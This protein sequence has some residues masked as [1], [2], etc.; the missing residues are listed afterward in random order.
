MSIGNKKYSQISGL[1]NDRDVPRAAALPNRTSARSW[2]KSESS[3]KEMKKL[4][5]ELPHAKTC[6]LKCQQGNQKQ[7]A[8]ITPSA[9]ISKFSLKSVNEKETKYLNLNRITNIQTDVKPSTTY[10]S[11]ATNNTCRL[12]RSVFRKDEK[13]FLSSFEKKYSIH[14]YNPSKLNN[15]SHM[16]KPD[17]K[18]ALSLTTGKSRLVKKMSVNQSDHSKSS[19]HLLLNG[20]QLSSWSMQCDNASVTLHNKK[21]AIDS[22]PRRYVNSYL[23]SHPFVKQPTDVVHGSAKSIDFN[24]QKSN[25]KAKRVS[26]ELNTNGSE[27]STTKHINRNHKTYNKSTKI[28]AS[29]YYRCSETEPSEQLIN[30]ESD[31]NI[32]S[33]AVKY[34]DIKSTN[35]T[36]WGSVSSSE[37]GDDMCEFDRQQ[38]FRVHEMFEEID[39]ILFDNP[40]LDLQDSILRYTSITTTNVDDEPSRYTNISN[41]INSPSHTDDY[42]S[43]GL[44]NLALLSLHSIENRNPPYQYPDHFNSTVT[45]C[46]NSIPCGIQDHLFYECKDWLSRFPHLRVVGKQIKLADENES[47]FHH[48]DS[49]FISEFSNMINVSS[50]TMNTP[51]NMRKGITT[52]RRLNHTQIEMGKIEEHLLNPPTSANCMEEEIFAIDGEYEEFMG[53]VTVSSKYNPTCNIEQGKQLSSYDHTHFR[54]KLLFNDKEPKISKSHQSNR[55]H[56]HH[57]YHSYHH[58]RHKH[59]EKSNP[60]P[61]HS[62]SEEYNGKLCI[63][64]DAVS[65]SCFPSSP[66][67]EL[68]R[69]KQP[70]SL[71]N[72]YSESDFTDPPSNSV[73]MVLRIISEQLWNDLTQ[74]TEMLL[75]ENMFSNLNKYETNGS[76]HKASPH[77]PLQS[78][79]LRDSTLSRYN[80]SVGDAQNSSTLTS[81]R[82]PKQTKHSNLDTSNCLSSQHTVQTHES[83]V[84]LADLLQISTK[85]LQTRE[86]SLVQENNDPFTKIQYTGSNTILKDSTN[87]H[88]ISSVGGSQLTSVTMTTITTALSRISPQSIGTIS[89]NRP[90]SSL[91]NKSATNVPR[92]VL[93]TCNSSVPEIPR[94]SRTS[95]VA[96][97]GVAANLYHNEKL[98]PLDR[99]RTPVPLQYSFISEEQSFNTVSSTTAIIHFTNTEN[100]LNSICSTSLAKCRDLNVSQLLSSAT[101]SNALTSLPLVITTTILHTIPNSMNNSSQISSVNTTNMM[102][103]TISSSDFTLPPLSNPINILST[104]NTTICF[105]PS[106]SSNT[107][108]SLPN[109]KNNLSTTNKTGFGIYQVSEQ[110]NQRT[111]RLHKKIYENLVGKQNNNNNALGNTSIF[112]QK[113]PSKLSMNGNQNSLKQDS[114][115]LP[116]IDIFKDR[117]GRKKKLW[118]PYSSRPLLINKSITNPSSIL[119]RACSTLLIQNPETYNDS[120]SMKI[121]PAIF[122]GSTTNPIRGNDA[123]TR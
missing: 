66:C 121:S 109:P 87:N 83:N 105:P 24:E 99:L 120:C 104:V 38:S 123:V 82:L 52:D 115:P 111:T 1:P 48:N 69:V 97:V 72:C 92:K 102:N 84:E 113:I 40:N 79:R 88:L 30:N 63:L 22:S 76:S 117:F 29:K 17:Y 56:V 20:S 108:S 12:K 51:L 45:N 9:C 64:P 2:H 93:L 85:T 19:N 100:S 8:N 13:D 44:D 77:S 41:S 53:G 43:M 31:D 103:E 42:D 49:N 73:E 18:H 36:D 96:V 106:N 67:I 89:I 116:P 81:F 25:G 71:E 98:A 11:A 78:Y 4:S 122:I 58:F 34:Y 50:T 7:L 74:W 57:N 3:N 91:N 32:N 21:G 118:R 75:S 110:N 14:S 10:S 6:G 101:A 26:N 65:N 37:W 47:T 27:Y 68:E 59:R 86:K 46:I 39:R 23:S 90:I 62:N 15:N 33:S 55:H 16:S 80:S 94:H 112:T 119:T 70:N 5:K 35:V 95:R 114:F 107:E 28:N 60:A 61:T 54:D